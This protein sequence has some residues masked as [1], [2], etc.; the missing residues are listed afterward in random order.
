MT[1]LKS[2]FP[3]PLNILRTYKSIEETK[4]DALV[5]LDTNI[6]LYPCIIKLIE[7]QNGNE[8]LSYISK[9]VNIFKSNIE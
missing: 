6:L 9:A 7:D 3:T 8:L 1:N 4:S 5:P 2:I